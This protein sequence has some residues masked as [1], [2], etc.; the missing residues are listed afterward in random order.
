MISQCKIHDD[1]R[2][3]W[4]KHVWW[5]REVILAI[6]ADAPWTNASVAKL[7]QNPIEM[8]AVFAPFISK[9]FEQQF[10]NLFTVHLK[11]GGDIVTA[12]KKGDTALVNK[13]QYEWHQNA[14]QIA[15]LM[16]S[17]GLCMEEKKVREM[18]YT[19]L[20]LTTNEA[21]F[22]LNGQYEQAIAEFDKIQD[23]ALMMADYFTRSISR[24]L[25]L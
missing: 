2:V 4:M 18:M 9:Q 14:E 16:A 21:V 19:H 11:L 24:A 23:E 22:M 7:L 13:L 20:Q 17:F 25:R 12:A 5:T 10:A 3:V 6:T 8:A 15:Q 1:M